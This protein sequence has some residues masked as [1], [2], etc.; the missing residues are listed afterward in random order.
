M[1]CRTRPPRREEHGQ[2]LLRHCLQCSH[3]RGHPGQDYGRNNQTEEC[4]QRHLHTGRLHCEPTEKI[5]WIVHT[6]WSARRVLATRP[7]GKV[8]EVID[9]STMSDFCWMAVSAA[10]GSRKTALRL[11]SDTRGQCWTIKV[12]PAWKPATRLAGPASIA[13]ADPE[14]LCGTRAVGHESAPSRC[15]GRC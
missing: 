10:Y 13:R 8:L 14:L 15:G 4:S 9:R 6:S 2:V 3:G 1:A 7:V 11:R 12:R 5:V